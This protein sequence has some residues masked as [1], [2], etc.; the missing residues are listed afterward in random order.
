MDHDELRLHEAAKQQGLSLLRN[1]DRAPS[2]EPLVPGHRIE[3]AETL[4]SGER[5]RLA[6]GRVFP[7]RM[8]LDQVRVALGVEDP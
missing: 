5:V 4:T 1:D 7:R 2:T 3:P 6:D 8:T